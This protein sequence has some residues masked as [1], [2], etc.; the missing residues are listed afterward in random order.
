MAASEVS[1]Q[2]KG[3]CV[4][5]GGVFGSDSVHGPSNWIK[6]YTPDL[7]VWFGQ[8]DAAG[9]NGNRC[10]VRLER[11]VVTPHGLVPFGDLV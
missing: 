5:F 9:A 3:M 1:A 10:H 2:I 6:Q 7:R 11:A 4:C 8:Q